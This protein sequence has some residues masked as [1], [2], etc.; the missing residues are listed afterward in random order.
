MHFE[1]TYNIMKVSCKPIAV[2][3]FVKNI[4]EEEESS[5]DNKPIYKQ[6]TSQSDFANCCDIFLFFGKQ[7]LE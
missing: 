7:L 5:E 2:N 6:E 3:E 1:N 4:K